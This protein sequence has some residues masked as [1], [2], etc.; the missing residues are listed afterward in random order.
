MTSHKIFNIL[1]SIL[2]LSE[3]MLIPNPSLQY[4]AQIIGKTRTG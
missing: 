2:F 4:L 3:N 1:S